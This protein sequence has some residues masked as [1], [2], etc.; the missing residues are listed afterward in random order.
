MQVKVENS[1]VVISVIGNW[2]IYVICA[3]SVL[4]I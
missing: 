1:D 3:I 2:M 4:G